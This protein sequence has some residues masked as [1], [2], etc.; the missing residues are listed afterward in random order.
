[1]STSRTIRAA[2]R[3]MGTA[4]LGIAVLAGTSLAAGAQGSGDKGPAPAVS[5]SPA[6]AAKEPE[7]QIDR[8]HRVRD[9]VVEESER[10]LER[11]AS[12]SGE[13]RARESE[14]KSRRDPREGTTWA[15]ERKTVTFQDGV[16]SGLRSQSE[17]R[18][19]FTSRDTRYDRKRQRTVHAVPG[20][21]PVSEEE[22]AS[23]RFE[24][25]T[26]SYSSDRRS[27]RYAETRPGNVSEETTRSEHYAV[28]G[29]AARGRARS[30]ASGAPALPRLGK[31]IRDFRSTRVTTRFRTKRADGAIGEVHLTEERQTLDGR[32]QSTRK[33]FPLLHAP[34]ASP[35][36]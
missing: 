8:R 26:T 1:M 30:A 36:P 23:E 17:E 27:V 14:R 32:I 18:E 5:A 11:F 4:L 34:D 7:L 13:V 35:R 2:V 10:K 29:K 22:V 19:T 16:V 28:R 31:D 24:S 3:S 9:G 15:R 6:P 25:S 12:G 21:D 20:R 33:T